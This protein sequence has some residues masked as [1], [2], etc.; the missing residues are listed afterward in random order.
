MPQDAESLQITMNP[1]L[2]GSSITSNKP[3]MVF[4]GAD[5]K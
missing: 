5:S 1:Y 2:G 4:T 3:L